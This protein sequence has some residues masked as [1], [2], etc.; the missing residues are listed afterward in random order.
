MGVGVTK[1]VVNAGLFQVFSA[2]RLCYNRINNMNK[3]SDIR[4]SP[5]AGRWYPANPK[6]LASSVDEYINQAK[7]PPISGKIV[8]LISPHAGH[9]YSGPVA[10][11]CFAAI[12]G[13]QPDLVVI[14]SPYHQYDLDP[15]LTSAHQAYQTPLGIVPIDQESLE[16]VYAVLQE[17]AGI[18]LK[19]V[20][21][22]GEHAIEILLP[23]FQRALDR[24]FKLLPLMLR[25][26]DPVLMKTLGSILADLFSE[27]NMV[28]TASTDLSHFHPVDT[29]RK[30]DQT[31][32]DQINSLDPDGLYRAQDQGK[33][34]ACGLGAVA[35]VI[36]AAKDK[37]KTKAHHLNYAHS[38]D[39]TGDNTSV[40]GY[41]AAVLTQE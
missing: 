20:R 10:G 27:K 12:K 9:I 18:S 4:P 40:V 17:R 36:W 23:F 38:G 8:G 34:A 1:S 7:L 29:A 25:S 3:I 41:T 32:I 21:N 19:R 15:I 13:L 39:I 33:G 28:L 26:Q 2:K 30:M 6:K 5:L 35:A 16:V 14:L 11:Y 31:I 37:G 24:D 22:D